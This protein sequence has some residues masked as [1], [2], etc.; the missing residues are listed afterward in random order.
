MNPFLARFQGFTL[1]F[2]SK[3]REKRINFVHVKVNVVLNR[4]EETS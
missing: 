3:N 2:V 1:N 4:S